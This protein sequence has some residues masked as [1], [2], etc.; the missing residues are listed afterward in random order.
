[1]EPS[2]KANSI[3]F[4]AYDQTQTQHTSKHYHLLMLI[5]PSAFLLDLSPPSFP[6]LSYSFP[7][8]SRALFHLSLRSAISLSKMIVQSIFG[9]VVCVAF[10]A[11]IHNLLC[12]IV[13]T[14][15][16]FPLKA[17]DLPLQTNHVLLNI[18]SLTQSACW[19][20]TKF[21]QKSLLKFNASSA[22]GPSKS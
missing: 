15:L 2:P 12:D 4:V 11:G 13:F 3:I 21:S 8:F 14:F 20:I 7:F 6:L 19:F 22:A 9:G 17:N 1:M 5:H 18:F 10:G 16:V